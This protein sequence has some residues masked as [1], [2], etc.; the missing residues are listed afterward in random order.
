[1]TSAAVGKIYHPSSFETAVVRF[2][3]DDTVRLVVG[4]E[5]T[6]YRLQ[7]SLLGEVSGTPVRVWA[8]KRDMYET[9]LGPDPSSAG[10]YLFVCTRKYL[11]VCSSVIDR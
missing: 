9:R 7:E 3:D 6:D 2:V 10:G 8:L 5:V 11:L 4:C 1:M